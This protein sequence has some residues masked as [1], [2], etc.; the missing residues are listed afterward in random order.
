MFG[1]WELSYIYIDL[2][3]TSA[4]NIPSPSHFLIYSENMAGFSECCYSNY[5]HVRCSLTINTSFVKLAP[6]NSTPTGVHHPFYRQTIALESHNTAWILHDIKD[7]IERK[8]H[9]SKFPRKY[10]VTDYIDGIPR[11]VSTTT[12]RD[13][14]GFH[15]DSPFSVVTIH[16]YDCL[17]ITS[18]ALIELPDIRRMVFLPQ[19]QYYAISDIESAPL[20]D[21][22][23]GFSSLRSVAI[24]IELVQHALIFLAFE[25]HPR[26]SHFEWLS[27]H[28]SATRV[29]SSKG[30]T[31]LEVNLSTGLLGNIKNQ[32][33][34]LTIP[35]S[36]L[37][38]FILLIFGSMPKLLHLKVTATGGGGCGDRFADLV[39]QHDIRSSPGT[40]ETLR[41]LDVGIRPMLTSNFRILTGHFPGIEY[42]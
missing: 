23:R 27:V 24:P 18:H 12:Q 38:P 40:F 9:L 13:R 5:K 4:T 15:L 17:Q 21:L 8:L 25:G 39:S 30:P 34:K 31:P 37:S 2:G 10:K 19:P 28:N 7:K 29:E 26:L 41:L 14:L 3:V 1:L 22:L 11:F 20:A 35:I 42:V 32:L 6:S 36:V 33:Q 16:R